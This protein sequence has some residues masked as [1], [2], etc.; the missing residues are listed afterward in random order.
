[1]MGTKQDF[2]VQEGSLTPILKPVSTPLC[3]LSPRSVSGSPAQAGSGGP[4]SLVPLTPSGVFTRDKAVA[5]SALRKAQQKVAGLAATAL[6][7]QS[8]PLDQTSGPALKVPPP[9]GV[10][11]PATM[12]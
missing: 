6:N 3:I 1:M 11:I 2:L 5:D 4:T 9:P 12:V 8:P 10:S 7:F